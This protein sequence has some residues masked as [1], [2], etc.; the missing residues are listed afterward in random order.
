MKLFSRNLEILAPCGIIISRLGQKDSNLYIITTGG[1]DIKIKY[2]NNFGS[3]FFS[4]EI[5]SEF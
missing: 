1:R 2:Y 5:I 4:D 3:K